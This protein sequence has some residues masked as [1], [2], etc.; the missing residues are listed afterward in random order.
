VYWLGVAK[1]QTTHD[2]HELGKVVTE[3]KQ[4]Y[5]DSPWNKRAIP[6]AA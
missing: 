2:H 1:Y 6:W 5:P 4:R 3:L